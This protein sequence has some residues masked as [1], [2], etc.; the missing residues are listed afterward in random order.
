[1]FGMDLNK[2]TN[3]SDFKKSLYRESYTDIWWSGIAHVFFYFL[4][5]PDGT[6]MSKIY[7]FFNLTYINKKMVKKYSIFF[8]VA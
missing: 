6:K 4:L 2:K 5:P 1:M 7:L 3:T 8:I